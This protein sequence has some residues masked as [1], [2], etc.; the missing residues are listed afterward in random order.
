MAIS[1]QASRRTCSTSVIGAGRPVVLQV[2]NNNRPVKEIRR[3]KDV[4]VND[5]L[6]VHR[7]LV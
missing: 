2:I 1:N 4:R 3:R 6:D 7:A 5:A